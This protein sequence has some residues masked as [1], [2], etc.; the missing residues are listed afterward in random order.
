MK[1]R[2]KNLGSP[3]VRFWV[4]GASQSCA[5]RQPAT[6]RTWISIGAGRV[7]ER[8]AAHENVLL[9]LRGKIPGGFFSADAVPPVR[10]S[11]GH[12]VGRFRRVLVGRSD[13]D[14]A[15]VAPVSDLPLGVA[16]A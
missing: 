1:I 14:A 16:R 11:A 13:T 2:Y 5:A 10:L 8:A 15:R 12:V 9:A 7:F 6:P 4:V 3:E